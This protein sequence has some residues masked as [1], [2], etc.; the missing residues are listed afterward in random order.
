[1]NILETDSDW[2]RLVGGDELMQGDILENCP[3]FFPP[4]DLTLNSL[5]EGE[6]DFMWEE[7]DVIIMSQSCDLAI[8]KKKCPEVLLC[9]L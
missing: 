4:L 7:R 8:G 6:A 3:I 1:M 2:Y 5:V 9:P